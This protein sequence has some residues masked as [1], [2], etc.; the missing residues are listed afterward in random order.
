M[1]FGRMKETI[2]KEI[3]SIFLK[4]LICFNPDPSVINEKMLVVNRI[5]IL[6]VREEINNIGKLNSTG[7]VE[8]PIT[9]NKFFQFV[10]RL[11]INLRR[12]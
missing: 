2:T 3:V 5:T 6:T 9:T 10:S 12:R 4:S 1:K 11:I 7:M 8:N